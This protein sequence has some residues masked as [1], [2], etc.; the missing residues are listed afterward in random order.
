MFERLDPILAA[1]NGGFSGHRILVVGDIMLDRYV[2]GMVERISP[3]A[4][5]PILRVSRESSGCGG[6][7]NVALNLANLGIQVTMAGFVGHDDAGGRVLRVLQEQGID[8]RGVLTLDDYPTITKTRIIGGHQQ[9]LRVDRESPGIPDVSHITRLESLLSEILCGPS[10]PHIVIL[11]DYGKGALAASLCH[12]VIQTARQAGIPVLVDPKG[13]D[14]AHYRGATALSPN[15]AELR[16][17]FGSPLEHLDDLFK[18]A[19]SLV[20]NLDLDH[21]LV[22]L[23]EQGIAL[24]DDHAN[25]QHIPTVAREVFDVSG[26]GDTVIATYAAGLAAGLGRMDAL[27]LAN[28]A[29]GL[30]VAKVGTTPVVLKELHHAVISGRQGKAESKILTRDAALQQADAWRRTGARIVFTNGCF[31]LLH[32][33]HVDYLQ[34]AATKGDHLI[35][36][37]NTDASVRLLKGPERPINP[38]F[39]RARILAALSFVDAVILFDEE[40]P[41]ELIRA[42]RPDVLVKGADYRE[43]QVVGSSDVRGWG[44]DV[45][46]IPLT[47]GRS[48]SRIVAKLRS[49]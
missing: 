12:S 41:L 8:P 31:D 25:H 26:A 11:S 18:A 34:Q 36:G 7:A 42:L 19:A 28:I 33:G 15:R 1:L 20:K 32:V 14:Y 37:L 17:V 38:E 13:R 22:T 9:L 35:I 3:E 39:D 4:P 2:W 16:A 48:T 40:T 45:V 29:A 49:S 24:V 21:M 44:G 23:S 30:V 27:H 5:V 10:A 47:A 46:L 6:A 43:D